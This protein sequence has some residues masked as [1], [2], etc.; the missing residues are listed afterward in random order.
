MNCG[1]EAE[2]IED[3]G[4]ENISVRFSDGTI[5][6]NRDRYEF[7]SQSINNPN[8]N[9][10]SIVGRKS[11][12]SCGLEAEVIEDYGWNDITVKFSNGKIKE[13]CSRYAFNAKTLTPRKRKRKKST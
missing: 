8:Y 7:M 3:N 5:I 1:M 6:R 2:V 12:M 10:R 9:K 13:H 4:S 11:L